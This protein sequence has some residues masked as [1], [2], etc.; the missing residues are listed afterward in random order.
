MVW[1]FCRDLGL[2]KIGA[3]ESLRYEKNKE[4]SCQEEI[5]YLSWIENLA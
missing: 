4:K 3:W 2:G 5:D 1:I